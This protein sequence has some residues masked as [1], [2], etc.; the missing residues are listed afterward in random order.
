MSNTN[1]SFGNKKKEN[2]DILDFKCPLFHR[3]PKS[4]DRG[5]LIICTV[6]VKYQMRETKH[7]QSNPDYS[8][9]M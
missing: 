3:G 6:K 2:P 5:K 7:A 9:L 4:K 1:E 8:S